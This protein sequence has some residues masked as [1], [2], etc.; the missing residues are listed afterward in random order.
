MTTPPID[1]RPQRCPVCG[2]QALE[3]NL[4]K[5]QRPSLPIEALAC[6]ACGEWWFES[7]GVRLSLRTA[8]ERGLTG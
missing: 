3:R 7:S 6:T 1:T 8:V 4:V 5:M 2:E